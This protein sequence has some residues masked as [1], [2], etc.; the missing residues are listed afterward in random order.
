MS[1]QAL[2]DY[3]HEFSYPFITADIDSQLERPAVV[4]DPYCIRPG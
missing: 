4:G 1:L 3:Y 2:A